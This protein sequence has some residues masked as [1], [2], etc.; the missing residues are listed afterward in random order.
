MVH[1]GRWSAQPLFHF[2]HGSLFS[3]Y[4]GFGFSGY[5]CMSKQCI[6]KIVYTWIEP[7]SVCSI[8]I[9]SLTSTTKQLIYTHV[10]DNI[11]HNIYAK[12]SICKIN[13]ICII[14]IFWSIYCFRKS[15][16]GPNKT[17]DI[18]KGVVIGFQ[19]TI[20]HV[21]YGRSFEVQIK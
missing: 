12:Y 19:N 14:N 7:R 16:L 13:I 4:V 11:K 21:L 9:V 5:C 2:S 18:Q 1:L 3:K 17:I 8:N 10:I 20:T 15:K 6:F